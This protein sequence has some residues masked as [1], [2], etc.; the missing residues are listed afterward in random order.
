MNPDE[1]DLFARG[2]E[3]VKF[4][5][6]FLVQQIDT[7][8]EFV[9]FLER[10][11]VS[12]LARSATDSPVEIATIYSTGM[13]GIE[14]MMDASRAIHRALVQAPNTTALRIKARDFCA[15]LERRPAI[16]RHFS[17]FAQLLMRQ[18]AQNLLCNTRHALEQRLAKW[19]LLSHAYCD[20]GLVPVTHDSL[21]LA[22]GARRPSVTEAL[23]G[24]EN[25]GLVVRQRGALKLSDPAVLRT[26][27]CSCLPLMMGLHAAPPIRAEDGQ[28][29]S[30]QLRPKCNTCRVNA[31]SVSD[32]TLIAHA[33]PACPR[34]CA[35]RQTGMFAGVVSKQRALNPGAGDEDCDRSSDSRAKVDGD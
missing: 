24:L 12:L 3:L 30:S 31:R 19:L 11:I 2:L 22:L 17:K 14:V 25:D 28:C 15:A 5:R 34:D 26:R 9:Y 21:A 1:F 8:I 7:P 13:V 16:R 29:P 10:G 20:D 33:E 4:D 27:A 23:A 18:S 6:G 35:P 32:R